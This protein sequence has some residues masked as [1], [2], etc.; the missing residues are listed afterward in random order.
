MKT[1]ILIT[2]LFVFTFSTLSDSRELVDKIAAVI[3][4]DVITLNEFYK[5]AQKLGFK[6]ETEEEKSKALDQIIDKTLLEQQA[7]KVGLSISD[8]EVDAT[9][10]GIKERLKTAD[11]K[12]KLAIDMKEKL[13]K[14]GFREQLKFQLLTRRVIEARLKGQVAIT[15]EEIEEFY[16]EN[17]GETAVLGEQIRIA[18]ILI[19]N[20][21]GDSQQKALEVY[22]MAV[23]GEDFSELAKKHSSDEASSGIGGDLGFFQKGDLVESLEV[24]IQGRAINEIVGPV[25]SP[26]GYH[27]IK[28]LDKKDADSTMPDSYKAQIRNALYNQK[29]EELVQ[30][31]LRE[32][33]ETAYIERKI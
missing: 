28:I 12:D 22:E 18:H 13:A 21:T 30:T 4:D 19:N 33:K 27:V 6:T 9:I 25:E 29:A 7:A 23:A 24:A 2:F 17:S 3:N 14:P 20:K 10:S 16:N 15:D 5:E 32:I 26:A 31:W 8:E 1:Q 11:K